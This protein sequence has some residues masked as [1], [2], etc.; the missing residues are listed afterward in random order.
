M[1]IDVAENVEEIRWVS[2]RGVQGKPEEEKE[3]GCLVLA[4][5]MARFV[6]RRAAELARRYGWMCPLI[7]N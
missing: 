5:R 2:P 6:V 4:D 7:S 1:C 3:G